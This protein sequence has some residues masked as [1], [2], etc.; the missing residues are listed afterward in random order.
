LKNEGDAAF[1]AER[2]KNALKCYNEA[3]EIN[4]DSAE[5]YSQK[6]L[7]NIILRNYEEALIDSNKAIKTDPELTQA[8]CSKATALYNQL[9][10]D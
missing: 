5:L 1:E 8:H 10:G 3:I 7:V 6:A 2:Y 4:K 9:P